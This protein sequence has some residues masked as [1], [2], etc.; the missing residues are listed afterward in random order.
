[1]PSLRRRDGSKDQARHAQVPVP[2]QARRRTQVYRVVARR[3]RYVV[4]EDCIRGDES[5][6]P[7]TTLPVTDFVLFIGGIR[8]IDGRFV[9]GRF[10]GTKSPEFNDISGN[11]GAL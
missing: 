5:G 10:Q 9:C 2:P 1:M 3:L 6:R 7:E 8:P 4:E 11:G